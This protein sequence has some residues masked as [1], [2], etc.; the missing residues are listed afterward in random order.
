MK[1][2]V[3]I[4]LGI[5][6]GLLLASIIWMTASPPRGEAVMLRPPP[7]EVPVSVYVTGAVTNPGL[8]DLAQG[9]RVADAIEAA[10]GFLPIADKENINLAVALEDGM[11]I[12]VANVSIYSAD[13]ANTERVNINTATADE[14]DTLPGIGPSTA[15]AIVDHRRQY[16]S[17]QRTDEIQ[18]VSGIGPATYD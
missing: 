14:L 15:Q 1:T 3:N 12:E 9:S 2:T 11:Q 6:V 8:Y 7:T 10:G 5:L 16:G 4:I 17:F 13:G 18:D